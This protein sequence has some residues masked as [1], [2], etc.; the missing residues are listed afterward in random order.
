[1][2]GIDLLCHQKPGTV[3]AIDDLGTGHSSLSYLIKHFGIDLVKIDRS[4]VDGLGKDAENEV[5][6]SAL[7]NLSHALGLKVVAEGVETIEQL[8]LLRSIGCDQTQGNYFSK[9]LSRKQRVHYSLLVS[10]SRVT[11]LL[12]CHARH[13]MLS[14]AV[15]PFKRS[16][17]LLHVDFA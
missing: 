16:K 14:L 11:T 8:A 13:S 3:L 5:I 2:C 7:I 10:R 9:P 6:L 1:M 12:L 15:N 17:S 4:F